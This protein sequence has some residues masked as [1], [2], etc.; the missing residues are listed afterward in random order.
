MTR[1]GYVMTTYFA[2]M[3]TAATGFIHPSARLVWN[4]SASVPIGLYRAHPGAAINVGDLVSVTPPSVLEAYLA[5]RHYLPLRVPLLK[6]V[7]AMAGQTVCRFG[8]RVSVD[9]RHLGNAL[10]NDRRGRPLPRWAGCRRLG[11]D[12]V[13]LMSSAVRDSFDGRYFGPLPVSTVRATLT[14]LWIAKPALPH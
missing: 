11:A 5:K 2:M 3:A 6:P 8:S 9:G 7:A 13:F 10:A 4:A 14:P 12:Q 1:F